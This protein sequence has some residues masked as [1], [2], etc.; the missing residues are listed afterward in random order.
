MVAAEA[1]LKNKDL[2]RSNGTSGMKPAPWSEQDTWLHEQRGRRITAR[3]SDSKTVSG[4]LLGHDA[5]CLRLQAE[6]DRPP[7][8]VYKQHIAYLRAEKSAAS[9]VGVSGAVG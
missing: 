5:Y 3:L 8:L 2:P 4:V 1:P 9:A 6:C 7:M